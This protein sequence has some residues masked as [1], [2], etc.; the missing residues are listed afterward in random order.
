MLQV[1]NLDN[2]TGITNIYFLQGSASWDFVSPLRGLDK[3]IERLLTHLLVSLQILRG[4]SWKDQIQDRLS[5]PWPLTT[6]ST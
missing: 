3:T 5:F 2:A 6:I 4:R 1:D